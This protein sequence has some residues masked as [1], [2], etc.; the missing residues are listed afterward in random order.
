MVRDSRKAILIRVAKGP[1]IIG[2][3]SALHEKDITFCIIETL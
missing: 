3:G 2:E 1:L